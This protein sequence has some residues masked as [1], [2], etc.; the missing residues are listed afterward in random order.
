MFAFL[1]NAF[2]V[3]S[4]L[5]SPVLWTYPPESQ[6]IGVDAAG[7]PLSPFD[8]QLPPYKSPR[9]RDFL[10]ESLPYLLGSG[11]TLCFDVVIVTQ[12]IIYGRQEELK[13][14][15]MESDEEE[16]ECEERE[17]VDELMDERREGEGE[18]ERDRLLTEVPRFGHDGSG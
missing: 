6:P 10:R 12:G 14:E 8:S 17:G 9:A 2:Y 18:R 4:L 7:S 5:S 11:G 13:E 1:G 15:D 16:E 3:A